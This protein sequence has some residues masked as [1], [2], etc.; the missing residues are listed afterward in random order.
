M[1]TFG[2]LIFVI[3]L[4]IV[5]APA[6]SSAAPSQQTEIGLA[7]V[8][9]NTV[10]LAGHDGLPIVDIGP[11]IDG[12][13][14]RIFWSH[15]GRVI[16]SVR[17]DRLY[18]A[19]VDGGAS[20]Q[21]PGTYS[22]TMTLDR[23]GQVLY[24]L[25]SGNPQ[26]TENESLLT[27]PLRE[28]NISLISSG[29]GRLVGYVGRYP[30]GSAS[31]RAV[32]AALSYA[33][34]GGLLDSGRPQLIPTYGATLFFSCCFPD[35]GMRAINIENGQVFDYPGSEGIILGKSAINQNL[36]RLAAPTIN[37]E[38]MMLD[39]ISGGIRTFSVDVGTIERLAWDYGDRYLY[40][41]VRQS[42]A[43]PLQLNPIVLTDIDLRSASM[44]IWRL[45]LVTSQTTQLAVLGDFYGI[46][47]MTVGRDYIFAAA[48]ESNARAVADLNAELLP[49]DLPADAPILRGEYL[50]NTILYRISR[51]GREAISLQGNTWG[52]AARPM[53]RI[54]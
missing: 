19:F 34:D 14:G 40:M 15:D 4:L 7:Y 39:L 49:G 3:F 37:N 23:T 33:Q 41:A 26:P 51:D 47:S 42:P 45:D 30:T 13:A 52:V 28:T 54:P 22:L 43:N 12:D 31:M 35:A 24:Y 5:A 48:V 21:L 11:V 17:R 6:A 8:H 2:L 36:S 38:I 44:A 20:V 10:T 50:P 27:F 1:K 16:Y 53:P 46:S 32:G 29:T 9:N 25:E 18:Q